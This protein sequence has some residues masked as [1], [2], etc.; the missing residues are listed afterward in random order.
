[1]GAAE[2]LLFL[3]LFC[4]AVPLIL[5]LTI[6]HVNGWKER[7]LQRLAEKRNGL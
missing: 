5:A 3:G 2:A 1:M 7:E 6:S 4:A